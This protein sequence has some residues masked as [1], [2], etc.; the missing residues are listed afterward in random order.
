MR[1]KCR[2][3]RTFVAAFT[4]LESAMSVVAGI[5][6]LGIMI[7]V[8][9]NI[10]ARNVADFPQLPGVIGY[11]EI[12]LSMAVFLSLA[13]TQRKGDHVAVLVLTSRLPLRWAC[14]LRILALAVSCVMV[15][16]MGGVSWGP[17]LE[18]FRT[19]EYRIGAARVHIWPARMVI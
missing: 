11:S 2:L 10:L 3:A 12:G 8:V 15:A 7:A 18:S 4:L 9:L 19:G 5:L 17:A 13:N 1:M 16:W 14:A 6:V